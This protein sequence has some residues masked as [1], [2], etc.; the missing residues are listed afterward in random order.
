MDENTESI[1]VPGIMLLKASLLN[2]KSKQNKN[3]LMNPS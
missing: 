3:L 1:V 2:G